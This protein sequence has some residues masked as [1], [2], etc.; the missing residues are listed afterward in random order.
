MMDWMPR[1]AVPISAALA[2]MGCAHP[3]CPDPSGPQ[4]GA[5]L[6]RVYCSNCHGAGAH[7][8]GP[9]AD[10]INVKVPDLTKIASRNGGEFPAEKIYRIIDG[11]SE[12]PAHGGRHMPVWGYE[13]FGS[14]GDDEA[15]HRQAS[16]RIDSVVNYLRTLQEPQ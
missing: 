4:S 5:Q 7:G 13:F 8:N 15:E 1:L 16:Q 9:V 10:I 3:V 2:L 6:F 12:I 14:E 11:Q